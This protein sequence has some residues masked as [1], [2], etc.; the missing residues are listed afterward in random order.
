MFIEDLARHGGHME[1]PPM[2]ELI[3][4]EAEAEKHYDRSKVPSTQWPPMR[5][6]TYTAE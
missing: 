6:P 4:V 3:A 2:G 1:M 5:L